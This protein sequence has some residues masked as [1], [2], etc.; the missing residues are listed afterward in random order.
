MKVFDFAMKM[1][2]DGKEYYEKLSSESADTGLKS[3]F[4]SLAADEQKH[5]EII[6]ALKSGTKFKMVDST[7][8]EEAKNLFEQ[9]QTDKSIAGSLKKSLDG[10][11]H[12]RKIEADSIKFY[13]DMAEKEDNPE[14]EQLLLRIANEERK[15]FNIMDNLCDFTLKPQN[16]LAWGEFSNLKQL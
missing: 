5:Y 7:A 12:A 9:L 2:L 16:F 11:E 14:I 1:E 15:H 10:Y 8:L 13:E 6:L 4:S 3:I